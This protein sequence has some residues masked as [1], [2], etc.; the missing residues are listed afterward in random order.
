MKTC[1]ISIWLADFAFWTSYVFITQHY[2]AKIR[3]P[4]DCGLAYLTEPI[5]AIFVGIF[6]LF[7]VI[8]TV[9]IYIL[10][11]RIAKRAG[12]IKS[13]SSDIK[14]V[15]SFSDVSN[16][17]SNE[18]E[19]TSNLDK[20]NTKNSV[21]YTSNKGIKEDK[22]KKALKTI[23]L[24]LTTFAICWLPVAFVFIIEGIAPGYLDIIWLVVG[25]WL[26]YG[27]SMLN[28]ICYALGNPYF[29]ETLAKFLFKCK[30]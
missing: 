29:R 22:E 25:Y 15:N 19:Y 24:L 13:T 21:N 6:I 4:L 16:A 11:F 8:V 14:S 18:T 12:V 26:G 9:V 1:L 20:E 23:A 28:P 10:I 30:K 2:Y 5:L 27:N 17:A 7:P 3:N